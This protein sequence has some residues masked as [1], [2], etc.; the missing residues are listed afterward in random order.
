MCRLQVGFLTLH[1]GE[2]FLS[3]GDGHHPEPTL[4]QARFD[5]GDQTGFVIHDQNSLAA[6]ILYQLYH[7]ANRQN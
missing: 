3:V 1:D 2:R 6:V 7:V 4:G 5:Q